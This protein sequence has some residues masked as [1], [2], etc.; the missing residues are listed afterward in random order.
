MLRALSLI[1]GN[2]TDVSNVGE[3]N[4]KICQGQLEWVRRRLEALD[5]I[6]A[7]LNEIRELVIYAAS[8]T[9]SEAET[10]QVQEW[11]DILQAEVNALDKATAWI[12]TEPFAH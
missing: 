9:L 12:G 1:T 10:A 3:I 8:R 4:E 2:R 7:K 11:I 6:E 5:K